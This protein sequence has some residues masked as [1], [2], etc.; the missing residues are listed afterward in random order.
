MSSSFHQGLAARVAALHA[1]IREETA[2]AGLSRIA[3]ALYDPRTDLLKTFIH[4]SDGESPLDHAAAPLASLPS[5]VELARSGRARTLNDLDDITLRGHEYARRLVSFGFY[6]SHTLSIQG[7]DGLHGFLFFNSF[8]RDFFTP[9]VLR[10]LKPYGE[11]IAQIVMRELDALHSIQSTV[12]VLL[13]IAAVRDGETG[14]HLT[15]MARY[16]RAIALHLAG[17][18]GFSDEFIEYLFQFAPVHDVGKISVPD[19]ILLKPG[20]LSPEEFE[21]MKGHVDS[22]LEIVDLAVGDFAF[23][24]TA[25]L[26]MLR[27]IVG[28][29]H[30]KIDGSGY[31]R[32]LTGEAIPLAARIVAVADVFDAL[33]SRRPYKPAWSN[34]E[35]L[36]ALRAEAGTKYDSDCVE[37]LAM[38]MDEIREIQSRFTET[39][40]G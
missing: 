35:A 22:G 38:C 36:A 21:V 27:Q 9:E 24:S 26:E 23:V 33:S 10:R 15:R 25:H 32:G 37:A 19:H 16:S 6:S 3:V 29:H 39:V 8:S 1:E 30:E 14:A 18:F 11:L 12:R 5:L 2:L 31:P 7:R 20:P 34:D 17:R 40:V 4:S 13:Q 28:C